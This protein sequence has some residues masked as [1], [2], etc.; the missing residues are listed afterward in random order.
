[1][2]LHTVVADPFM[3]SSLG[4]LYFSLFVALLAVVCFGTYKL[5]KVSTIGDRWKRRV[6]ISLALAAINLYFSPFLYWWLTMPDSA[7]YT[8]NVFAFIGSVI[9]LLF[10]LNCLSMDFGR[11]LGD[12]SLVVESRL[13][14]G[15]NVLVLALP[16]SGVFVW[17]A[18][19]SWHVDST[20]SVG[21]EFLNLLELPYLW[22]L[23]LFII[24]F[25]PISLTLANLW[26]VK[27][28]LVDG[29]KK[30]SS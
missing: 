4:Q 6:R 10:S 17:A 29:L 28:I 1:M 27:E 24:L 16:S 12:S 20:Q 8:M 14:L 15:I 7:F 19:R 18:I 13:F 11:Y 23:T 2:I 5:S 30:L 21:L 3:R 22:R 25:L 26:R 9:L